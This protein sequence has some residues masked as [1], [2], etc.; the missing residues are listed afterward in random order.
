MD[1]FQK[2]VQDV[3]DKAKELTGAAKIHADIKAEE[4]R[5][6]QQYYK[7]GKKYYE[8][9]KDAPEMDLKE[10]VDNIVI[11]NEK[12][13]ELRAKLDEMKEGTE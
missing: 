9:F 12:I 5:I 8:V 4:L 1:E 7:L 2:M 13:W 11:S 3:V 6:K 10:Y